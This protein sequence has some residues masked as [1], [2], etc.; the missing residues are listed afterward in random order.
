MDGSKKQECYITVGYKGLP[1]TNTQAY[2]AHSYVTKKMQS[3]EYASSW[4]RYA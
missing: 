4:V 3:C 1:G 2:W